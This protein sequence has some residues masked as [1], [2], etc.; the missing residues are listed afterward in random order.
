MKKSLTFV[1]SLLL[2]GA[3]AACDDGDIHEKGSYT[4]TGRVVKMTGQ[5]S[6][7]DHWTQNYS[8]A[9]AGF[10]SESQYAV[11]NKA[12]PVGN[13]QMDMVMTNIPDNVD[14]IALCAINRLRKRI[15]VFAK[16]DGSDIATD[17]TIHF[18]V[19]GVDVSMMT[20]I[21]Q[22]VF[23]TTCYSC[24]GGSSFAAAGLYLTDGKSYDALVG[25]P[26][27]K[28]E[29]MSLVSPGDAEES[30]LHQVL[31]TDLTH[32][33]RTSH[34]NMLATGRADDLILLIDNWINN[35]AENN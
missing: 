3:F 31:A 18:D 8:I 22:E 34:I 23:N 2:A 21:Q 5:I 7:L 12:I 25:Q 26:S 30:V 9:L 35:G 27:K 17:D 16:L 24:H 29:G 33:W 13:N 6:G 1:V 32:N 15:V 20:A 4:S 14:E 10:S 11:I 28:V 19:D